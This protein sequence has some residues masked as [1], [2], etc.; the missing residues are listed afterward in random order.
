MPHQGQRNPLPH[1]WERIACHTRGRE[2]PCHTRGREIP[3]HTRGREIVPH[4]GERIP[5]HT[6]GEKSCSTRRRESLATPGE[7]N[8]AAP[9]GEYLCHTRGREIHT[10]ESSPLSVLAPGF[11]SQCSLPTELSCPLRNDAFVIYDVLKRW[12][13]YWG[14]HDQRLLPQENLYWVPVLTPPPPLTQ[15]LVNGTGFLSTSWTMVIRVLV[16]WRFPDLIH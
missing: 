5:C 15:S 14:S 3:C 13:V 11:L 12:S 1:Q 10:R 7:R 8:R 9:G 16:H 4:Q 6:R 2:I